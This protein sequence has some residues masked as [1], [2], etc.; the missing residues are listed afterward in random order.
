[1]AALL[2][3]LAGGPSLRACPRRG[4]MP[5]AGAGVL[6]GTGGCVALLVAWAVWQYGSLAAA[7]TRLHGVALY[8]PASVDFGTV[9]PGEEAGGGGAGGELD[10]G[11]GASHRWHIGLLMHRHSRFAH[12]G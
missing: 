4:G 12:N 7:L 5:S 1:M 10:C 8:A 3:L 9:P 11:A 2:L 6:L